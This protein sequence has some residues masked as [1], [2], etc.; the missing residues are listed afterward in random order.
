V[1]G[2]GVGG[3]G[4]AISE[5]KVGDSVTVGDRLGNGETVGDRLYIL[6]SHILTAT[7][8]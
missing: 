8:K 1:V 5:S 7:V 2:D 4:F 6:P 3:A